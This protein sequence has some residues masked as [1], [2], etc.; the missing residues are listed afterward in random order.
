MTAPTKGRLRFAPLLLVALYHFGPSDVSGAGIATG[1]TQRASLPQ[2]IPALVKRHLQRLQALSVGFGRVPG[3][4]PL[5][6]LV[7]LGNELLDASMLAPAFSEGAGVDR[8]ASC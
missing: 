4:L 7:L 3:R 2:E 5:P 6:Q 8:V 1:F